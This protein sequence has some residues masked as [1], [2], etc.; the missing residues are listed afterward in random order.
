MFGK[1][2]KKGMADATAIFEKFT[3]KQKEALEKI[4]AELKTGLCTLEEAIKQF[5][6][7][8]IDIQ[9]AFAIWEQ[10]DREAYYAIIMPKLPSILSKWEKLLLVGILYQLADIIR[11]TSKQQE[12]IFNIQ[13]YWNDEIIEP[14]ELEEHS[15]IFESIGKINN[16]DCQ[17]IIYQIVAEYLIIGTKLCCIQKNKINVL[18]NEFRLNNNDKKIIETRVQRSYRAIGAEGLA[19]KYCKSSDEKPTPMLT[20]SS[21]EANELYKIRSEEQKQKIRDN[22]VNKVIDYFYQYYSVR[23]ETDN[24][25]LLANNE[26]DK[27]YCIDKRTGESRM[28]ENFPKTYPPYRTW[29]SCEDFVVAAQKESVYL[30]DL[31][32]L[33]I[34]KLPIT[35]EDNNCVKA[36][37]PN[38]IIY[39]R[40]KTDSYSFELVA[41]NFLS[42]ESCVIKDESVEDVIPWVDNLILYDNYNIEL[43]SMTNKTITTILKGNT[44]FSFISIYNNTIFIVQEIQGSTWEYKHFVI[45]KICLNQES[46]A[47]QKVKEISAYIGRGLYLKSTFTPIY[48][49]FCYITESSARDY[50]IDP[51]FKLMYFSFENE[52]CLQLAH[53]VGESEIK[54]YGFAKRKERLNYFPR[55]I[56]PV[57]SHIIYN[58][59]R[60]GLHYTYSYVD[61]NQ[62][63]IIHSRESIK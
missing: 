50:S 25:I 30:F 1:K 8:K 42:N 24:Y 36:L 63:M 33:S 45:S 22:I 62:P 2:Y 37:M 4:S 31:N 44:C 13:H 7:F 17:L 10:K 16:I 6:D 5:E 23:V 51:Q 21:D 32:T 61:I 20:E 35:M 38:N 58:N 60:L 19:K 55:S 56:E 34:N 18:L 29:H 47:L 57:N 40:R 52:N 48:N 9:D 3:E 43:Y 11:A 46:Y 27:Y 54:K 41:Y 28:C 53:K 15:N 26:G 14:P 12:F 59:E 49:G 39:Q